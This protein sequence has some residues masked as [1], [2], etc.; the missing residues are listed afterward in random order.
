MKREKAV[1]SRSSIKS[2]KIISF[3]ILIVPLIR[4]DGETYSCQLQLPD[5]KIQGS[6]AV[7]FVAEFLNQQKFL[8]PIRGWITAHIAHHL[9]A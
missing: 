8:K 9:Q 2:L 3:D 7:A 5:P 4:L 1:L 6:T